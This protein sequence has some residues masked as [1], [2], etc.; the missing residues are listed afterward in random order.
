M[1]NTLNLV[2]FLA[3]PRG[4]W[5][6]PQPGIEPTHPAVGSMESSTTRWPGKSTTY[7]NLKLPKFF[8]VSFFCNIPTVTLTFL[9]IFLLVI[10]FA[11]GN[12]QFCE[13][14]IPLIRSIPI[15][16]G[17]TTPKRQVSAPQKLLTVSTSQNILFH[18]YTCFLS[19]C[20]NS[21]KAQFQSSAHRRDWNLALFVDLSINL[22]ETINRNYLKIKFFWK[23][24]SQHF[25]SFNIT[26]I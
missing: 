22:R 8:L 17:H 11:Y 12:L 18:F 6:P 15:H 9:R 1:L 2:Y 23:L 21:F 13:V 3:T 5:D 10:F 4:I 26:K 14:W 20:L 16:H 25:I 7:L 19:K 24:V